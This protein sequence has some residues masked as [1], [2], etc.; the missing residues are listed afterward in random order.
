MHGLVE[1]VR[2]RG[3]REVVPEDVHRLFAMQPMATR[4]REQRSYSVHHERNQRQCET[5]S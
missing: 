1:V 2:G 4:E 3:R 5:A